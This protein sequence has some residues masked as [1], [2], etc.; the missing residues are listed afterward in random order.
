MTPNTRPTIY[1]GMRVEPILRRTN[2]PPA[3]KRS[4]E[5]WRAACKEASEEGNMKK[6]CHAAVMI[7]AVIE[8]IEFP[9]G[10]NA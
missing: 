2:F 8:S 4:I 7:S 1:L 10:A 9:Q 5:R 3:A 6:L